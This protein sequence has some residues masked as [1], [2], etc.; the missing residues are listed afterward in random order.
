MRALAIPILRFS[1][2]VRRR[3]VSR[4][5]PTAVWALAGFLSS[6]VL[7][8]ADSVG[9]P[10]PAVDTELAGYKSTVASG[11][12]EAL[13]ARLERSEARLEFATP[14]G[15]LLGLLRELKIPPSSQLLVASKTSPNKHYISPKNPR[16]LYF[17]DSVALAYVPGAE[18]IEVAAADP[19]LDVV[20]YTLEQ[21]PTARPRLTRDDRC[22]E[23]HA[24]AKTLDTPGCLVRSFLTDGDGEVDVLSGLMVTHRTPIAERW[25]GYY[26]TGD[27]G[28]QRHRGNLFGSDA[29][30]RHEKTADARA[31][32]MDLKPF[33]EVGKFLEPSIDVVALLVFEH[34]VHMMNLLTRLRLDT[35]TLAES[36]TFGRTH[37]ATEA[38]LKYLLFVAE[39]PLAGPVRGDSRF[40]HEFE[41]LGPADAQW[42]SLRQ[43]DL[44]TRI[45]KYPCSFMVYSPSFDAL[46]LRAKRHLYRRLWEVLSGE[47]VSPEFKSLSAETRA[48]IR[49]ILVQTK[50]DMPAYWRL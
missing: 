22:M 27:T 5:P 32:V 24:S 6:T 49:D 39:A 7:E 25:G 33:L 4:I 48:G 30:A 34:Q 26:V 44:R 16:A 13:H 12:V 41:A 42:R 36:E 11:P 35:E 21:K 29:F 2:A 10:R 28:G 23:C 31:S 20:F 47:D 3:S 19:K 40:A 1:P 45:F 43:F 37:P 17:N 38:V 15:Y 46:P 18:L 50:K 14:P 8:A 9:K